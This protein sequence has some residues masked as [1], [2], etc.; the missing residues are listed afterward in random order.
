[1]FFIKRA[2]IQ[3]APPDVQQDAVWIWYSPTRDRYKFY[4]PVGLHWKELKLEGFTGDPGES[5]YQIA[6]DNGFVGTEEQW[7]ESLQ[8]TVTEEGIIAA[9]GFRPGKITTHTTEEWNNASGYIPEKGEVIIYSDYSSQTV[10]G[11]SIPVPAIKIGSGNGYVQDLAFVGA[12]ETELLLEHIHNMDI[13]TTAAQKAF[14]N[15]KLNV[16][17]SSEVV[18]EVLIFNR[19]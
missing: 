18:G 11:V 15:N 4:I 14:W 1:M 17:D 7:L 8:A 2:I 19:N 3:S 10:D 5:A 16:N 9:L 12:N 13:H 6:V